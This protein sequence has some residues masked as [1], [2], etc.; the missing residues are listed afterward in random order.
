MLVFQQL[1][2]FLKG[3]VGVLFLVLAGMVIVFLLINNFIILYNNIT[4]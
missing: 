4:N 2:T 3:A 1:F